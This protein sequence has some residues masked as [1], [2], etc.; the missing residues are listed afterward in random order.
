MER[1]G[2]GYFVHGMA[3][4]TLH[5]YGITPIK[6][7]DFLLLYIVLYGDN[8]SI[9][10]NVYFINSIILIWMAMR[11]AGGHSLTDRHMN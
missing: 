7:F 9:T 1:K 5:T 3:A 10:I 6:A 2:G 4:S 11:D 8:K